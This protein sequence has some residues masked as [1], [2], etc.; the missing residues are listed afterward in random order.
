M[1]ILKEEEA[2]D[3]TRKI[4]LGLD[5]GLGVEC[6][7]IPQRKSGRT[8]LCVSSQA[9][10]ARGCVFCA[11]GRM[12]LRRNLSEQEILAQAESAREAAARS[13]MAPPWTVVFMGMGEPMDNPEAVRAAVSSLT[14]PRRFGFSKRRVTVST[15]GPTPAAFEALG[16]MDAMMAWSL[17]AADEGLRRRLV[18]SADH[19]PAVLR[20]ALAGALAKRPPRMRVLMIEMTLIDGVNDRVEDADALAEF[21]APLYPSAPKICVD[22]IPFNPV[23]GVAEWRQ[24]P[25]ERFLAFQ[26]RLRDRKVFC[27][28]RLPRGED[29]RAA[30][31]QLATG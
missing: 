19:P 10:C 18:P 27:S 17:H 25:R 12:G 28:V 2:S 24:S 9:G 15:I 8:T 7:L 26:R 20:D 16:T 29:V 14:D 11:T 23:G 31:G 30:C 3:G 13:G 6:V 5:D 22:L 1:E 21:L 4:L